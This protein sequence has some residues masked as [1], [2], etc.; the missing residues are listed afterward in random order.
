MSKAGR[1]RYGP[2]AAYSGRFAGR[3]V[4]M[5]E[6]PAYRVLSLAAHRVLSRIEI[7]NVRHAGQENGNLVVTYEQFI[8][9]GVGRNEI[10]P[11]I[12]ELG[13]LGFIEV[14]ARGVAGNADQKAPNKFR[15][16][17][18]GSAGTHAVM[19]DGS[20]EWRRITTIEEAKAIATA[21]RNAKPQRAWRQ[22][23][24][25]KTHTYWRPKN[26][27]PVSESIPIPVSK[28]HTGNT[29][30]PVRKTRLPSSP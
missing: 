20:H 5:L 14:T 28:T 19:G 17:Y 27:K 16:T 3:L 29:P 23:R 15:L 26:E 12:R 7:E 8:A 6:S 13:A 24:K 21:A 30:S 11:A 9:Y 25:S 22:Q 2:G 10:G 18:R 1:K 4:E